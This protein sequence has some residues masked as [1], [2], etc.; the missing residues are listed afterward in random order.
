YKSRKMAAVLVLGLVVNFK[1]FLSLPVFCGHRNRIQAS[2]E[3]PAVKHGVRC[4]FT[5]LDSPIL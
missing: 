4:C 1:K 2:P 3:G 5:E